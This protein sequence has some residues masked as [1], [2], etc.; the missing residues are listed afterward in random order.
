MPHQDHVRHFLRNRFLVHKCTENSQ[1]LTVLILLKPQGEQ[2]KGG[3][4]FNG[5]DTTDRLTS[6]KLSCLQEKWIRNKKKTFE[7][8]QLS[9]DVHA[10]KEVAVSELRACSEYVSRTSARSCSAP[11]GRSPLLR[12][13]AGG[14]S[15]R[16][17]PAAAGG[18]AA[19][20]GD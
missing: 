20:H 9:T 18:Q 13:G 8:S 16:G 7:E 3:K 15:A 17:L 14:T 5:S 11:P 6:E 4:K 10:L 2:S 19:A 1:S 12:G